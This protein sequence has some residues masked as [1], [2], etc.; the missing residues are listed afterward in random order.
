MQN[1]NT[2]QPAGFQESGERFNRVWKI[3]PHTEESF[4][5]RRRLWGTSRRATVV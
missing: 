2:T 3:R 4:Q 5:V 1:I